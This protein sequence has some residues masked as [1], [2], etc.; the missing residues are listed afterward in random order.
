MVH[1]RLEFPMPATEAVVFDAFHDQRWRPRWD[2]L[3]QATRV[4][5][6]GWHP[7]VGAVTHNQGGGALRALSM[8]TRFVTY[9]RPR[10]AAA[11]MVGR[12]FPFTRWAASM[13]HQASGSGASVLIYSYTFEV[14]PHVLRWLLEPLVARLF[15]RQTR[16]RF[17]RL[18][19]FLAV[20]GAELRAWQQTQPPPAP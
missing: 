1:Q 12:S 14:G 8:S 15:L 20:H 9:D 17:A 5:G 11:T 7:F 10:V 4:E 13:R 16:Q 6:G 18:Q 3:V 2:P 19:A